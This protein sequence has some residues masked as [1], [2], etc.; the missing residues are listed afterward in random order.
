MGIEQNTEGWAQI[1]PSTPTMID[2]SRSP[3]PQSYSSFTPWTK[4]SILLEERSS[5]SLGF[6]KWCLNI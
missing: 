1:Y 5:E 2:H 4:C 6:I 3:L